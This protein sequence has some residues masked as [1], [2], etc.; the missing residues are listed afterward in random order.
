MPARLARGADRCH[1][2]AII[3]PAMAADMVRPLQL[4]A[5]GTLGISRGGERIMRTAHIAARTRLFSLWNCHFNSRFAC[6]LAARRAEYQRRPQGPPS[7]GHDTDFLARNN[8][9]L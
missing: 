6:P 5:I 1:L 9:N 3:M 7:G 4:T 2:A 8:R